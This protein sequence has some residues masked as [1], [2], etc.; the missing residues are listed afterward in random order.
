M[1]RTK[2][3]HV[4]TSIDRGGAENQ[5]IELI[6]QQRKKYDV[7]VFPLI[8]KSAVIFEPEFIIIGFSYRDKK[9]VFLIFLSIS[10]GVGYL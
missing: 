10:Y 4:I 5:L 7:E 8:G 6:D 9:T 2:L 1:H 3:I